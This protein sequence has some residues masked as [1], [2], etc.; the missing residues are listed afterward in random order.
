MQANQQAKEKGKL[1]ETIRG[2]A[3]MKVPRDRIM[4]IG[5]IAF[6]VSIDR[7]QKQD[8]ALDFLTQARALLGPAAVAEDRYHL[9]TLVQI[10]SG[11]ARR[12]SEQGFGVIEPLIG[13]LNELSAAAVTMN[14]FG[15]YTYE[16]GELVHYSDI[17]GIGRQIGEALA[18]LALID[19]DRARRD[20]DR[21]RLPEIRLDALL[22]IARQAFEG[23]VVR[24]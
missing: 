21:I 16:K 3:D 5:N 4:N 2:L 13:Q 7:S 8:A 20:V 11:F 9:A 15:P 18:L 23:P 17:A 22:Q 24:R 1:D 14:G 6:Q 19:F 12:G 10:A